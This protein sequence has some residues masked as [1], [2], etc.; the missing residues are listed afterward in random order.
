MLATY[1]ISSTSVLKRWLKKYTSHSEL[2]EY[3]KVDTTD[4]IFNFIY[5]GLKEIHTAENQ[6]VCAV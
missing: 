3:M 1:E 5:L 2:K 4:Y 6:E